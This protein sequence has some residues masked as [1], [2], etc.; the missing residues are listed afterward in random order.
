MTLKRKQLHLAAY[1]GRVNI[2][3]ELLNK[4]AII[5][6]GK[7]TGN[8]TPLHNA[9]L[10]GNASI[11]R[12]LIHR[13][14][15][16][17]ACSPDD[18]GTVVNA[19]IYSGNRE[20]IKLLIEKGASLTAVASEDEEFDGPLALAAQ[21]S[22]I[23]MFEY[24]IDACADKLPPEEYDKALVA[25]A[26]AGRVEVFIKLLSYSHPQEC[27]QEALEAATLEENWDIIMILL[28][29]C[30]TDLEC[31]ALFEE[32]S[33]TKEDQDKVLQAVWKHKNGVITSDTLGKALI[34][35][36]GCGKHST[37]EL[38]LDEFHANPNA[39]DEELVHHF[40]RL[41]L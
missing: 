40:E 19:A 36:A 4:G 8:D 1:F 29:R 38:L 39:A 32:A 31:T 28:D 14:A 22:D 9:A 12:K 5:D 27:F 11:M 41:L 7:E 23:S 15:D 33:S 35:A 13:G 2:V 21:L 30:Q 16:I 3:E 18:V 10:Q 6:D 17:N 34:R 24:L 20:A 25:A 37:V 26:D